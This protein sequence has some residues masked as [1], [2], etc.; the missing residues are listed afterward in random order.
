[1]PGAIYRCRQS[2]FREEE[3]WDSQASEGERE[4]E[5]EREV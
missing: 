5:R 4:R 3:I 1:M 2:R